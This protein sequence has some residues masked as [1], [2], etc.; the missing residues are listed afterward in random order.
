MRDEIRTKE[1]ELMYKKEN[2][3]Y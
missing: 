1:L 2:N 3:G